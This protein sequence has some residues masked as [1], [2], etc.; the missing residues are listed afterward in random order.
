MTNRYVLH[1]ILL[2]PGMILSKWANSNR[3]KIV[4]YHFY[5][6]FARKRA[7]KGDWQA[8]RPMLNGSFFSKSSNLGV[9][10]FFSTFYNYSYKNYV[11]H[12]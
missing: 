4:L 8:V 9:D 5:V 12:I 2:V 1:D 10:L 7:K 3:N 6:F 11:V